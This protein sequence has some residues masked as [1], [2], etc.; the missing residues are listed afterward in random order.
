MSVAN[1]QVTE[2]VLSGTPGPPTRLS[3]VPGGDGSKEET[4]DAWNYNLLSV[5]KDNCVTFTVCFPENHH[6]DGAQGFWTERAQDE[7]GLLGDVT[8]HFRTLFLNDLP[9]FVGS[10]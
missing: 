1:L 3:V 5:Q 9:E 6:L 4:R 7:S 10:M 2:V 8:G